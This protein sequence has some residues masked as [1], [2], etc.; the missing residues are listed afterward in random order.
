MLSF[1]FL[2]IPIAAVMT[3]VSVVSQRTHFLMAL[4]SLEA[5]ILTLMLMTA[6]LYPYETFSLF[7]LLTFGA[8]EA[9]LGLACMVILTRSTGSDMFKLIHTTQ[10]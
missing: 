2:S 7:I 6:S 4:L 10:C 1:L 8:S 3:I 5:S 9:A